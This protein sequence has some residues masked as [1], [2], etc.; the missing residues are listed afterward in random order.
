MDRFADTERYQ[1]VV[2][3]LPRFFGPG[4]SPAADTAALRDREGPEAWF[5]CGCWL[6]DGM[7]VWRMR[8]GGMSCQ[9]CHCSLQLLL[10]RAVRD[11]SSLWTRD[12]DC[13]HS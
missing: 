4:G 7:G 1:L 8:C 11:N 12:E 10:Y 2:L 6:L 5:W 13:F 3:G 9:L